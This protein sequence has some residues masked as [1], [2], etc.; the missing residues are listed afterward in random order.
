M[1]HD[2]PYLGQHAGSYKLVRELGR[3][4]MGIVYEGVHVQIGQRAAV[5]VMAP[6]LA[7]S[8]E[9]RQRFLREAQA[10]SCVRHPGLVRVMDYG[11]LGGGTPYLLMELLEGVSLRARLS[12]ASEQGLPVLSALKICSEVAEAMSEAHRYQVIHCD[13]KPEN[14]F[15]LP[16]P[17]AQQRERVKVL[18]FGIARR[19]R[20]D[21]EPA[22]PEQPRCGTVAYMAPERC[23]GEA[24]VVSASDVYSLGCILYEALCGKP[25]FVGE[26][27]DVVIMHLKS[28]PVPPSRRRPDLPGCLDE[29]V[30]RMLAKDPAQRPSMADLSVRLPLLQSRVARLMLAPSPRRGPFRPLRAALLGLTLSALSLGMVR[31][32]PRLREMAF[33]P[34]GTL[35]TDEGPRAISSLWMDRDEVTC[36]QFFDFLNKL[37]R[38]P[39]FQIVDRF[40]EG[41]KTRIVQVSGQ[42]YYNIYVDA[43]H[44]CISERAG[45]LFLM[46]AEE[47]RPVSA[48]TWTAADAYCRAHGKRLPTEHEWQYVASNRGTTLYPWGDEPPS[49]DHAVVERS[50]LKNRACYSGRVLPIR[51]LPRDRTWLGVHDLAGGVREW[52]ADCFVPSPLTSATTPPSAHGGAPGAA[53]CVRRLTRGGAWSLPFRATRADARSSQLADWATA[54]TGF[55][56]VR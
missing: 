21:E 36:Q 26:P 8:E 19:P 16:D 45:N 32:L 38:Y 20:S 11:L 24:Q 1:S 46:T 9:D 48:V 13:L 22:L 40:E 25:P 56:C 49:C 3:G 7:Q 54:Y 47:Q 52:T 15:L 35:T 23:R 55:R 53:G 5:K 37:K 30:L 34:S 39:G 6:H 31:Y 17:A 41:T 28:D 51:A 29:P 27:G 44:S 12:A 43:Q 14:L 33:V 42:D 4:G 2:L 10:S 50:S 18:D